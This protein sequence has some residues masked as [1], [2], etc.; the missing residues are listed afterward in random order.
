MRLRR[1]CARIAAVVAVG[2]V[3]GCG[4]AGPRTT[5]PP[6]PGSGQ[7]PQTIPA[8]GPTSVPADPA[9]VAVIKKWSD[10]LRRGNIRAAAAYFA[11]PSLMINGPDATGAAIIVRIRSR[12]EAEAADAGLPCGAK[13]ISADQ[14]GRFVN[15]LFR[16]TDRPGSGCGPGTGQTARTNFVVRGGRIAEWIR[17]PDDPGDNAG[18]RQPTPPPPTGTQAA[19]PAV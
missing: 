17:A 7:A 8:P 3:T 12:A 14:R 15:V 4:S 1:A 5:A 9:A 13:F 2:I 10:A 16:L 19:T 6:G 11:L 18:P